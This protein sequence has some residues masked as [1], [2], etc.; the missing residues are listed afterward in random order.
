M[1][2]R[3]QIAIISIITGLLVFI[4][5]RGLMLISNL[6]LIIILLPIILILS[7]LSGT[8]LTIPVST[9]TIGSMLGLSL[10]SVFIALLTYVLLSLLTGD[11]RRA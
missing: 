10:F 1:K 11:Y 4:I 3:K 5:L 9:T 7:V 2:Q 6:L 8:K